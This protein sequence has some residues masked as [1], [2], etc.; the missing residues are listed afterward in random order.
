MKII[1]EG[2]IFSEQR[3]G[4]ISRYF[5]ELIKSF[6]KKNN[7]TIILPVLLSNNYYLRNENSFKHFALFPNTRIR[8][9][10]K[11]IFLINRI[12]FIVALLRKDFDIVH[13]TYYDTYFLK[14][15]GSKK[16][17]LTIYEISI[18]KR[19]LCER[20]DLIIAISENTKKDLIEIFHLPASKIR[21]VHLANSL[22]V[23]QETKLDIK[24]PKKYMLF[25]GH[26]S[27]YKNFNR[28]I[29][30]I[31]RLIRNNEDLYLICGGG[32][33][34]NDSEIFML[35]NLKVYDK[36]I[37]INLSD[38]M[39]S[40]LYKNAQLFIFPSVYEGFGIPILE[41]FSCGCPV[42]CSNTSSL[43]EVAANGAAYFDPMDE[44]SIYECVSHLLLDEE[45]KKQLVKNA[46][47]R[48]EKFS[49]KNTSLQ[50]EEIYEE[51]LR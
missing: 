31:S 28:F 22:E 5:Y 47:K 16:L 7:I 17:I 30:A 51:V 2:F 3:Y 20:A 12:T 13:P 35:K 4:G 32:H 36:V 45:Y 48:L 43:P 40:S 18:K 29:S 10:Q 33:S 39:L 41:S 15:I 34:F 38:S 6:S 49:W 8:G 14:Y 11:F 44:E 1:Y 9:K 37:Q 21:V 19:L 50:T 42:A 25:I 27:L 46:F 24:L 23:S 26:R